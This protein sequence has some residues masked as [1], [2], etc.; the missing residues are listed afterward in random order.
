MARGFGY[1]G[2]VVRVVK[3]IEVG[4][5]GQM[6][7]DLYK[8]LHLG[9]CFFLKEISLFQFHVVYL[10]NRDYLAYV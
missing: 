9:L 8:A 7:T 4:S 1:V 10:I 6:S 2:V 5:S 3:V